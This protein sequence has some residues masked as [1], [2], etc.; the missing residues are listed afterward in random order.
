MLKSLLAARED[1]L[2]SRRLGEAPL[3]FA[4][5]S[6]ACALAVLG[7]PPFCI[8]ALAPLVL[9]EPRLGLAP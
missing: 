4:T 2:A 6:L 9:E 7:V 1:S 3:E 8:K 5:F